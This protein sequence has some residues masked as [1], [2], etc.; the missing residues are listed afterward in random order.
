MFRPTPPLSGRCWVPFG[1]LIIP[2]APGQGSWYI[3]Y[4]P[5][6]GFDQKA[7][8]IIHCFIFLG[9]TAG[10]KARRIT[11]L[12]VLV[13]AGS[14]AADSPGCLRAACAATSKLKM[15]I[16][17]VVP[18]GLL[19]RFARRWQPWEQHLLLGSSP[20]CCVLR[21]TSVSPSSG[22]A[23]AVARDCLAFL[24][25]WPCCWPAL[26]CHSVLTWAA[27]AFCSVSS[28]GWLAGTR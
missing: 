19:A 11:G 22:G 28:T 26:R 10:L 16:E 21:F 14:A 5:L 12:D 18:G 6:F 25:C 20:S 1:P 8:L 4:Q 17:S 2:W 9:L 23:V 15:Q 24:S 3:F 13:A 27:I 7:A